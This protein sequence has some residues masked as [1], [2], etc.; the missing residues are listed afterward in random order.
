MIRHVLFASSMA[1]LLIHAGLPADAQPAWPMGYP[2]NGQYQQPVYPSQNYTSRG[3]YSAQTYGYPQQEY[4]AP[5][6]QSNPYPAQN[7]YS[8]PAQPNSYSPP[9][10]G[11][12]DPLSGDSSSA[13]EP[14]Q[15]PL[16]GS[17]LD[18]LVAPIA[19]YPDALVAQILAA[20]TYPAQIPAADQWLRNMRN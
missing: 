18:Q 16:N 3:Y 20:S 6:P 15:Q 1:A 14:S 8:A 17:Q 4:G 13:T 9:G 7:Y 2:G 19:L 10:D 11:V 5:A 12:Y